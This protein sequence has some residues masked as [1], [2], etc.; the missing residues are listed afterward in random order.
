MRRNRK[1]FALTFLVFRR[2]LAHNDRNQF[3]LPD[4]IKF[5]Q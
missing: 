5:L 2:N 4:Y 1:A 3:F